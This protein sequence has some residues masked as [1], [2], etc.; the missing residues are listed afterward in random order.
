MQPNPLTSM[1]YSQMWALQL[2]QAE[3]E[4]G[5]EEEAHKEETAAA[6]DG[7]SQ[8]RALDLEPVALLQPPYPLK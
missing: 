7:R 6:T 8:P 4:Q 1:G 2:W 3:Q 5:L